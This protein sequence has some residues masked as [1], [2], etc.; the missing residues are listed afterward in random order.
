[1]ASSLQKVCRNKV[2]QLHAVNHP[3]ERGSVSK[4]VESVCSLSDR[5]VG[6]VALMDIYA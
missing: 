1:M 5:F 2:S 4:L 3:V 6:V